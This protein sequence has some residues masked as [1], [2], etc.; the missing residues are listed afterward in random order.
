MNTS[1]FNNSEL[2]KKVEQT[3]NVS[4]YQDTNYSDQSHNFYRFDVSK[5]KN[6]PVIGKII[7]MNGKFSTSSYNDELLLSIAEFMNN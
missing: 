6:S 2:L 5:C 7:C 4:I 3:F 1:R